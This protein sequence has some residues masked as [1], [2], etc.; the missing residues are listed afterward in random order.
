MLIFGWLIRFIS[1]FF[2]CFCFCFGFGG[3][4]LVVLGSSGLI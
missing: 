1:L 2:L 4:I 3:F